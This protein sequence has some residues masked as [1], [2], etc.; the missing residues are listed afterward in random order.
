MGEIG[1]SGED[2]NVKKNTER[3]THGEMTDDMRL[4]TSY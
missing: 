3:Q 1:G 4:K 2:E